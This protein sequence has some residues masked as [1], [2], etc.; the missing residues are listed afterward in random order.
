MCATE[1]IVEE[2][3]VQK[4]G[5]NSTTTTKTSKDSL[6]SFEDK[7]FY[8]NIIK[9]YPHDESLHLFKRDLLNKITTTPIKLLIKLGVDEDNSIDILII[10]LKS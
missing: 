9:S 1:I 7:I 5:D 3:R 4:V 6:S 2:C 10:I 8:V